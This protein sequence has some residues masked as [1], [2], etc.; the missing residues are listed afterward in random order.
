MGRNEYLYRL[1]E[2]IVNSPEQIDDE[3]V[4]RII[5]PFR[6]MNDILQSKASKFL[7]DLENGNILI[8]GKARYGLYQKILEE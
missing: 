1:M 2:L 6:Q 3:N 4:L 5:R 8:Y 7:D